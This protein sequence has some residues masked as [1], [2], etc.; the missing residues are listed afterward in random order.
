MEFKKWLKNEAISGKLKQFG[1]NVGVDTA[2]GTAGGVLGAAVGGP[3]GAAVGSVG[4]S[5]VSQLAQRMVNAFMQKDKYKEQIEAVFAAMNMKDQLRKNDKVANALDLPDELSNAVSPEIKMEIAT[6]VTDY[7]KGEFAKP[8]FN[9]NNL[10][11]GLST[12]YLTDHI[13]GII[14]KYKFAV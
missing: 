5:I 2:I 4:A 14:R 10:P 7:L 3:V 9:I 1:A 11:K 12:K 13:E 8:G 6:K